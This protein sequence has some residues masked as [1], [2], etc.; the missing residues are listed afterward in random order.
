MMVKFMPVIISSKIHRQKQ[1][2]KKKTNPEH[3]ILKY[4]RI[5]LQTVFLYQ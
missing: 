1:Q 5:H 4:E 2:Q 3:G